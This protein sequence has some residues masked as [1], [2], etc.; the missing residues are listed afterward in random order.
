MSLKSKLF[1]ISSKL[2]PVAMVGVP[3]KW[4]LK[5]EARLTEMAIESAK[6]EIAKRGIVV[7]DL[8]NEQIELIVSD[9]RDKILSKMKDRSLSV[10]FVLLGIQVI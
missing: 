3:R 1:N 8:S 2:K 7:S 6:V 5:A 9:E 4:R 10:V